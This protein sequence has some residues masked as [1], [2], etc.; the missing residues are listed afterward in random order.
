MI[1]DA[2][3]EVQ[4]GALAPTVH[5]STRD[6][7]DP[8]AEIVVLPTSE[9]YEPR[10][11][12]GAGGMGEVRL[13]L[14]R[15]I[16]REV[17]IK[18]V[19]PAH[20]NAA[21]I[22]ARFAREAR[23]QGQLEHPAI[24]PVYDFGIDAD[25]KPYFTMKRVRGVTLENVVDALRRGDEATARTYTLHKLLGAFVQVCFA[26]DFAHEHGVL[27]R[28]L[29]PS[30]V[31]LGGYGEVYVLDWGLAKVSS[32]AEVASERI[33][34]APIATHGSTPT[35]AGSVLGTPGYMAPEQIHGADADRRT[36][37]Y[38]LGSILFEILTHERLH[39]DGP[40]EVM[41]QRTLEG[42]DARPSV[43]APER[44]IAPELEAIV[45]RACALDRRQRFA[46]ARELAEAVEAYA[47]GDRD[48]A[49][50]K[51]LAKTHL[52]RARD[53][54]ARGQRSDALREVGR[55]VALDPNEAGSLQLLVDL[56]TEPPKEIPPEVAG[57]VELARQQTQRSM[58]PRVAFFYALSWFVFLP[59]AL[60]FGIHDARLIALPIAAWSLA[61]LGAFAAHRW[62]APA[63]PFLLV[64]VV[65]PALAIGVTSVVFGP[66]VLTAPIMMMVTMG[67]LLMTRRDR[68]GLILGCNALALLVPTALAWLGHHPVAHA[69]SGTTVTIELAAF[70]LTRDGLF[71]VLTA[72]Y[73]A[74]FVITARFATRYRDMLTE[75]ETKNELQAWQLRQLVPAEA[76]R[77]FEAR[78]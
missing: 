33:P 65:L 3:T 78:P 16:G 72:V 63:S 17:A 24:V 49:L 22:R 68:R 66:L 43:R 44:E 69:A 7:T 19:L 20:A 39:G 30:N 58:L 26:I 32:A 31:M 23:V 70:G 11:Q 40:V 37:V 74:L 14:D 4:A 61:A 56:L 2:I 10:A 53:A 76:S 27:H 29:K 50:R 25:G 55:A 52:A 67:M 8:D 6:I 42:V 1:D 13:G 5:S 34:K 59:A 54:A 62:F 77:A 64:I 57:A 28:D 12:L 38:A 73:M 75:A 45:V 71:A 46:S 36:D 51:S 41:T 60:W 9:R 35:A 47:S 18:S 48:L 21:D 15:M